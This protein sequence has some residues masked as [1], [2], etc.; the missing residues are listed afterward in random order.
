MAGKND[1]G[2]NEF[3]LHKT[4]RSPER[5]HV[6]MRSGSDGMFGSRHGLA[7][8]HDQRVQRP[9]LLTETFVQK[10]ESQLVLNPRQ[11]LQRPQESHLESRALL[12]A[13]ESQQVHPN[14]H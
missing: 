6:V 3:P 12:P 1:S 7:D 14:L 4:L 11:R 2:D 8:R 10:L 13:S 9:G 5:M